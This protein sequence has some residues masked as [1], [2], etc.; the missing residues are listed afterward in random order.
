MAPRTRLC[1][2]RAPGTDERVEKNKISGWERSKISVQDKRLLK[3]MGLLNKEAMRMP[4]DESSP[5]PPSGFWRKKWLY[6][7]DKSSA[8]QD[9][10]LAPFDASEDIQ[11]RKSWDAEATAEE[12]AATDAL[13]ARIQ[14]L[15]NTKGAELSSV[16]II[17]HFLRI[18]VQP[19]Q[20]RKN[21]LWTYS[22]A[23]D[24]DRVFDDLPL[25]YLEKLVRRF[26][27]LSKNNEVPFS[28]RVEPFSGDHALPDKSAGSSEKDSESE[29]P[30]DSA[31]SVSPPP[32]ASPD[33]RKRKRNIDEEDSSAS[34][35]SEPAA[36]EQEIFDPYTAIGAV[37]LDDE[38]E[39]EPETHGPANTSTSNTLVLSEDRR[40][41]PETSPPAQDD[42]EALTP[43]P[44]PR[45]PKKKRAKTGDAGKQELATGSMS[46]PLIND[47]LMKEMVNLGSHFIGFRDEAESLREALRRAEER[48][49]DLEEKLKASERARKKARWTLLV[50]KIFAEDFKPVKMP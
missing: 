22:G 50:S 46:T 27:S 31:H 24:A 8:A 20:A 12:K 7:K 48:A 29:Q 28:C 35:L 10:G 23:E 49:D 44:S 25:K 14:E 16:Q 2:N 45:A 30:S 6:V 40:V 15:Q 5:H 43:A 34:K 9:Y 41:A 26:T 19:L 21:P 32:A 17:A 37:S 11:R 4:G 13:I 36:E 38:E 18:R 33:K 42:P 3:R 47:P 1:K 39:L